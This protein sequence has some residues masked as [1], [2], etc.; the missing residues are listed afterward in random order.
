MIPARVVAI[1]QNVVHYES[2][3]VPFERVGLKHNT[4]VTARALR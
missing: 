2:K 3:L 4:P 1:H